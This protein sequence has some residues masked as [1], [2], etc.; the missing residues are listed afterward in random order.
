MQA[1]SYVTDTAL[2]DHFPLTTSWLRK[3]RMVSQ[4]IPFVKVGGRVL[5]NLDAVRAALDAL[6]VGGPQTSKGRR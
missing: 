6:T 2:P 5:Y 1:P 3:D 4:R